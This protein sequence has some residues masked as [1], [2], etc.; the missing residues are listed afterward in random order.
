MSAAGGG[1]DGGGD[2]DGGGVDA[3]WAN[4]AFDDGGGDGEGLDNEDTRSPA[5]PSASTATAA[6]PAATAASA[7]ASAASAAAGGGGQQ[8][9]I[10]EETLRV[11][12]AAAY[13]LPFAEFCDR[14]DATREAR[15]LAKRDALFFAGDFEARMLVGQ[16]GVWCRGGQLAV[17]WCG[18]LGGGFCQSPTAARLHPSLTLTLMPTLTLPPTPQAK[19][20]ELLPPGD[21]RSRPSLYPLFKLL[22]PKMDDRSGRYKVMEKTAAW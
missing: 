9:E 3:I 7:A 14:L 21:P 8:Q 20:N 13:T 15:G 10:P 5:R 6:A 4:D 17:G 18:G 16:V 11:L 12:E 2:S 19:H 1:G 22:L